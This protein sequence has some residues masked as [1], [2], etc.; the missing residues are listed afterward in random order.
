MAPGDGISDSDQVYKA[1]RVASKHFIAFEMA[2]LAERAGSSISAVM[3]GALAGSAVLPFRREAY[4][5]TIRNAGIGVS[6]SLRAFTAGFHAAA[7]ASGPDLLP[8]AKSDSPVKAPGSDNT[9]FEELL[10]QARVQFPA[11]AHEMLAAGLR[12]VVDFQD[13]QYGSEYL[14]LVGKFTC[15]ERRDDPALVQTAAKYI[16]AAMAYDDVIRV[17]DLKTRASRFARV[18]QEMLAAPKQII[19][20]TEFLHPRMD[21]VVGTLPARLGRWLEGRQRL[22]RFLDRMINRGRRVRTTTIG[23]FVLL[24]VMAGMCRFRRATLRHHRETAHRD[25]WLKAA[26]EA[27]PVNYSL[28]V[29]I[30]QLRRLVKGYSDTHARGMSKF[31]RAMAAALRLHGRDDAADWVRRLRQAALADEEGTTFNQALQTIDTFLT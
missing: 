8:P 13:M 7:N 27:A 16:A 25:A 14:N 11:G 26:L 4:E 10:A 3:F 21:E 1:A 30:L 6:A 17:A 5:A 23:G 22:F 20:T 29:E 24:Y 19:E 12:R 2:D 15:Y 9:G 28:A 18:R 31:D